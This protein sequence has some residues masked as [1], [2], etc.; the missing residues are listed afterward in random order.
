[1][2]KIKS[3]A[4]GYFASYPGSVIFM[5]KRMEIIV[6]FIVTMRVIVIMVDI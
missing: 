2:Q 5:M 4:V 3:R 1:M 6:C